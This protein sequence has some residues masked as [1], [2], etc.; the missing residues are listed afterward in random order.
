M[1]RDCVPFPSP[2]KAPEAVTDTEEMIKPALMMRSAVPPA[3][4][5]SAFSVNSSIR[6]R[7]ATRHKIVPS[8]IMTALIASVIS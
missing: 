1:T 6:P 3:A 7:D 4:I 8:A 5:V 2:S